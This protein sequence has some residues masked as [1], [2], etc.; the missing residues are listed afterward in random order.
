MSEEVFV[1][2]PVPILV[3]SDELGKCVEFRVEV[4][5]Y[6]VVVGFRSPEEVIDFCIALYEVMCVVWK[7]TEFVK[8]Y[9]HS[10]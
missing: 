8:E 1:E 3:Q 9:L 4:E 5:G 10:R 2:G 6:P 7:D